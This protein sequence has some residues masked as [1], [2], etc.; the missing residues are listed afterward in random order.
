MWHN[1]AAGLLMKILSN[2]LP[3]VILIEPTI[4]RDE[5]GLF[6]EAF[7]RN[8]YQQ[9][10]LDM[11]FV[12]VNVS[13]SNAGVLRGLH[14]QLDQPQGKLVTV[15]HGRIF[16]VVVDMRRQST[17]FGHWTGVELS[18]HN[19]K[20]I[21]IPPGFS[22][23]FYTLSDGATVVYKVTD[24][25]VPKQARTLLWNDPELGIEWPLREAV[26]L[27]LNE[28][29]QAGLPLAECEVYEDGRWI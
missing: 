23:G 11:D 7:N 21:W 16:D 9:A 20:L 10:G 4:H 8:D 14:Y 6:Y 28:A 12:Q 13:Y 3:G 29:D 18:G 19:H 17:T 22:H 26:P 1:I 15:L 5:R 25:Y 2:E 24:Y 27:T